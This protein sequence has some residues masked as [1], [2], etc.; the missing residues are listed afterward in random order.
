MTLKLQLYINS[1]INIEGN[2]WIAFF[3]Y[4]EMME[5]EKHTIFIFPLHNATSIIFKKPCKINF[6][7]IASQRV[8]IM[9]IMT[10]CKKET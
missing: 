8:L 4:Q 7:D 6:L 9:R 5:N 10:S 1:I 2:E 3:P